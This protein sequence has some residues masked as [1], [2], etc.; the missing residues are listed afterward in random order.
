[1]LWTAPAPRDRSAVD[2]LSQPER[3]KKVRQATTA[4]FEVE[5][6]GEDRRGNADKVDPGI[7]TTTWVNA[8]LNACFRLGPDPRRALWPA[9]SQ[10]HKQAGHMTAPDQC[11][12]KSESSC[13]GGAVHTWTHHYPRCQAADRRHDEDHGDSDR[14]HFVQQHSSPPPL[15]V[16]TKPLAYFLKFHFRRENAKSNF[17]HA[18]LVSGSRH[19]RKSLARLRQGSRLRDEVHEF[20]EVGG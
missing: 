3:F 14:K 16:G 8:S 9:A 15:A 10:P 20:V 18:D 7:G 12:S 2:W 6:I 4:A 17:E 11:C 5:G 1:M 19:A 13:Q